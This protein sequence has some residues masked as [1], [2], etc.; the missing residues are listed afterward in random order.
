V[1][2][3]KAKASLNIKI[4]INEK[5]Q[6]VIDQAKSKIDEESIEEIKPDNNL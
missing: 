1:P 6:K 3:V 4:K 5:F 2:I